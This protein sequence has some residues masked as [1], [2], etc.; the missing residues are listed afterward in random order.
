MK[1]KFIK[2]ALALLLCMSQQALAVSSSE[3][4]VLET[5][6]QATNGDT[7]RHNSGWLGEVGTECSW[8]GVTCNE[9]GSVKELFFNSN[10]LTG[11]IPPELGQLS[12]LSL[13]DL[14]L[15][16]LTGTI[17]SELQNLSKLFIFDFQINCL[18][19]DN[20]DSTVATFLDKFR[21]FE[22]N[23]WRYQRLSC[24]E[25]ALQATA[26]FDH[27]YISELTIRNVSVNGISYY[28]GLIDQGGQQFQL[29]YATSHEHLLVPEEVKIPATYNVETLI[30]DIPSVFA[31]GKL[32]KVKMKDNGQKLFTILEA[33]EL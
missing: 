21:R 4:A 28:A 32:Y 22:G 5:L 13:L 25:I 3:R 20:T 12:Q 1:I 26:S 9:Q 19:I 2:G 31:Y 6:Y 16:F 18:V 10:N 30:L 33:T 17:P 15:N 24:S 29:I 14:R 27:R 8:D 23:P 7:W 11:T